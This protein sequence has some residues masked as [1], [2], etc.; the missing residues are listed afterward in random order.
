VPRTPA[1][2]CPAVGIAVKPVGEPDAVA[3]HVRFDERVV[4]CK[5]RST[6][7][8]EMAAVAKP[9]EQLR[10]ESCVASGNGRCEA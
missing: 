7:P 4:P 8:P 5:V 1:P 9:S 3:P 2:T 6:Q 10:T